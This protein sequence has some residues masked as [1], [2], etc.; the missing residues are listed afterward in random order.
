M[1]TASTT[2]KKNSGTDPEIGGDAIFG[3][4]IAVAIALVSY[5]DRAGKR[6]AGFQLRIA[7]GLLP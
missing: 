7:A 4:C 5:C 2:L 1:S 6:L 3:V